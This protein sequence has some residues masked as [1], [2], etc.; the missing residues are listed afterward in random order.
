[1]VAPLRYCFV[2]VNLALLVLNLLPFSPLD[3]ALAWRLF[4]ALRASGGSVRQI[5]LGWVWRWARRR[6]ERRQEGSRGA[7]PPH[8]APPSAEAPRGNSSNSGLTG[9]STAASPHAAAAPTSERAPESAISATSTHDSP[10]VD[11]EALGAPLPSEQAQREI[12]ALLRRV[13]D[14]AARSRRG[15]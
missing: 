13:Q 5:L 6:R 11:E 15:R 10:R 7:S 2:E 12:D 3:G 8:G 9:D 4:G 1:V 14:R